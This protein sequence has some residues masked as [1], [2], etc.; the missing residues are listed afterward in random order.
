MICIS[1]VLAFDLPTHFITKS[2][3]LKSHNSIE[4]VLPNYSMMWVSAFSCI[5]WRQYFKTNLRN[6]VRSGE[7]TI[8]GQSWQ[9]LLAV[10]SKPVSLDKQGVSVNSVGPNIWDVLSCFSNIPPRWQGPQLIWSTSY[11]QSQQCIRIR[12]SLPRGLLQ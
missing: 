2:F 12:Q 3:I 10:F 5:V 1:G 8:L 4:V 9:T 11:Q 6:M 7:E